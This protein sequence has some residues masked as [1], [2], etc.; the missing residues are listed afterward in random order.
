MPRAQ[1]VGG[2]LI[3]ED[4]RL[5]S[6]IPLCRKPCVHMHTAS[7]RMH[8]ASALTSCNECTLDERSSDLAEGGIGEVGWSGAP[9]PSWQQMPP[10]L[11]LGGNAQY[12]KRILKNV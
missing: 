7:V 12:S 8:M 2:S 5:R 11:T 10:E 4:Q 6:T 9:A 1:T 3:Y